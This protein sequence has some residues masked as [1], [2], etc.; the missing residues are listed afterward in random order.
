MTD[1]ERR[2]SGVE[3]RAEGRRLSGVVMPYGDVSPTHQ[4]RFE[5]RALRIGPTVPLNIQHRPLEA[6]AWHPDGGL[7]LEHDEDSLRMVADVPAIPAG[8]VALSL[9]REGQVRGLSV[10]F[11][12][13]RET[14]AD[15]LRVIEAAEL[16]GIALVRAPSYEQTSVEAR[17]RRSGRLRASIPY[18]K[19]LECRCHKNA[20]TCGTVRYDKGAFSE[21][22]AD[23]DLILFSKDYNGPIASKRRGTL[24]VRET[25]DGLEIDADLPDTSTGADLIGASANVPLL[26]RPLMDIDESTFTE[27][28]D[29][30][31]YSRVKVRALLIGATDAA[32]GW[33]EA[34]VEG[35]ARPPRRRRSAVWL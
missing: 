9:V 34:D 6:V 27:A 14:H 23:D 17:R 2:V 10:E 16:T 5:P 24:R 31:T 26:V 3:L 4:E 33:P 28:G 32:E 19:R 11:R 18:R 25:D 30:A 21:A 29:L 8:D 1:V 22:A 7:R 12:A 35:P 20:G 15:G 13:Q